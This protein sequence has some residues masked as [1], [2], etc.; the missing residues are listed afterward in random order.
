MLNAILA[1]NNTNTIGNDNHLIWHN[2]DDMKFFKYMTLGK[3]ILM[4]RKT[5]EGIGKVLPN[6]CNVILTSAKLSEQEKQAFG[7]RGINFV[8]SID[9]FLSKY[10]KYDPFILG[11]KSLYEQLKDKIDVFYITRINDNQD[12]NIKLDLNTLLDGFNLRISRHI[13]DL[14]IEAYTKHNEDLS[15]FITYES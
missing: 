14:S 11:G 3:V 12:G 4:G 2:S 6:R 9:E 8:N 13:G 15:K 10:G 5:F 1:I 7:R